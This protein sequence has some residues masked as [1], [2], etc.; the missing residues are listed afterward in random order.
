VDYLIEEGTRI[1]IVILG[2]VGFCASDRKGY[3]TDKESLV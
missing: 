3:C 1:S 2:I